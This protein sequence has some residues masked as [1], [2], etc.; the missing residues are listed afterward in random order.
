MAEN[1]MDRSSQRERL[2]NI[3]T[4][5]LIRLIE[6]GSM[7]PG[8]VLPSEADIGRQ[9]SVSKT[10]VREAIG[11]LKALGLVLVHQ[12]RPTAVRALSADPIDIYIRVAI[13]GRPEGLGEALELRR[14]LETDIAWRAADRATDNDLRTLE[15]AFKHM[16][17]NQLEIERWV[18]ADYNFH[19]CLANCSSNTLYIHFVEALRDTMKQTMRIV[20]VQTDLRDPPS[21]IRRHR[22]ILDAVLNRDPDAARE[23]MIAHFSATDPVVGAILADD[24]RIARTPAQ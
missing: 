12:G 14:A 1:L 18:D 15:E 10:V 17:D 21:T 16:E 22:A 23:A 4:R 13:R 3:V 6:T 20:A 9:M 5:E 7:R 11:Q 19:F 8:D 2:S 24:S